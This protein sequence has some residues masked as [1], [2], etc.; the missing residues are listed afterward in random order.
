MNEKI[1]RETVKF[2]KAAQER[3]KNLALVAAH[4]SMATHESQVQ[5]HIV[6]VDSKTA[7]YLVEYLDLISPMGEDSD[8]SEYWD[9][10]YWDGLPDPPKTE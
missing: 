5:S 7:Q 8:P 1:A 3:F 4:Q 6:S 9:S 10:E 2:G